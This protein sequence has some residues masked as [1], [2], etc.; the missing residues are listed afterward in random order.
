[1][2]LLLPASYASTAPSAAALPPPSPRR[3]DPS[4]G[5]GSNDCEENTSPCGKRNRISRHLRVLQGL[6]VPK[7]LPC[8]S[9]V[10]TEE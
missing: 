1:M 4:A 8:C 5:G 3:R 2:V 9:A 6:I 7:G 10:S